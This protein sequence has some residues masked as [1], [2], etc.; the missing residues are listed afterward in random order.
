MQE[1]RGS[2][3]LISTTNEEGLQEVGNLGVVGL[4]AFQALF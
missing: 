1:V 4:F 2:N 3:P